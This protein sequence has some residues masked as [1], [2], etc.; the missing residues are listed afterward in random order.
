[1]AEYTSE[2]FNKKKNKKNRRVFR[3]MVGNSGTRVFRTIVWNTLEQGCRP[4][5][6]TMVGN[7]CVPDLYTTYILRACAPLSQG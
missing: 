5:F 6:R 4:V 3:T 1:M 2:G 7:G